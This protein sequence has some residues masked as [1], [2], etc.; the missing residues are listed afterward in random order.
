M[1]DA[2]KILIIDDEID[3]SLLLKDYFVRK[4]YEVFL[5]HTLSEGKDLLQQ[6][7]PDILILDNNLPDG[8]GWNLAPDIATSFPGIYIVLVS[9]FHP[10]VPEMP[11]GASFRV[12]EK[13]ITRADLD[14]QFH[15]F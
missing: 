9:A 3:L 10:S 12:I 11:L 8:T 5:T 1:A 13:P 6:N 15:E 2:K 14:K 4:K 7:T